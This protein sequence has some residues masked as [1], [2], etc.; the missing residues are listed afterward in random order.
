M[1]YTSSHIGKLGGGCW[2]VLCSLFLARLFSGSFHSW[3]FAF[4]NVQRY[5]TV[6]IPNMGAMNSS[7]CYKLCSCRSI[8]NCRQC[9]TTPMFQLAKN[10][11]N[12]TTISSQRKD[13]MVWVQFEEFLTK[14]L[15]TVP[16]DTH[17]IPCL[18]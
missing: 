12:G 10:C 14:S 9:S 16:A 5:I 11:L 3:H 17:Q 15:K 7:L 1:F 6:V 18:K 8:R 2:V 13:I 4:L